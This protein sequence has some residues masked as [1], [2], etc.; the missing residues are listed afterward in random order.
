MGT[1]R[2]GGSPNSGYTKL[3]NELIRNLGIGDSTFRFISW[4]HS[5]VDGFHISFAS[6]KSS[7]GY[8]RDKIRAI[9]TDAEKNNYL[10]RTK[11]QDK[12]GRYDWD[13]YVFIETSECKL[14]K[15][16]RG[17][18]ES[19]PEV[20]CPEVAN[21]SVVCPS[22]GEPVD[23]LS[24]GGC[25]P[26]HKKNINSEDQKL[27][28]QGKKAALSEIELNSNTEDPSPKST[29][30]L[31]TNQQSSGK[32]ITHHEGNFSAAP[33]RDATR[34][35]KK[36]PV[37]PFGRPR[38]SGKDVMWAWLPEGEWVVN[39]EL[40]PEFRDWVAAS[41]MS[42]FN[43]TI[44]EAR[45]NVTSHFKNQPEQL[46][47]NWDEYSSQK[48]KKQSFTPLPDAVRDWQQVQHIM[49]WEQYNNCKD[50][51]HFYSLRSWNRAYL[52]YAQKYLPNFDWSKHLT[53]V[54]A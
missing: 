19:H 9:I 17:I 38:P 7:L 34:Q 36:P 10:V 39:G 3:P 53:T 8:G 5:H 51:D 37:E 44:H 24:V 2:K 11:I 23:G 13:Y 50:L 54:A 16:E 35:Y 29:A 14:F 48:L 52:E 42:K 28:D 47:L 4:V 22:V 32:P 21:P 27:E 31:I 12:Q 49:V 20:V 15:L 46:P 43:S 25:D 26:P 6:I 30:P 45:R 33:Q 1:I 40:D 41:W 18:D